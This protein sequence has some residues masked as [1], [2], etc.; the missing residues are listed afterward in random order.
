[1]CRKEVE[2]L[3]RTAVGGRSPH[4][5]ELFEVWEDNEYVCLILE[6]CAGMFTPVRVCLSMMLTAQSTRQEGR[7]L[8]ETRL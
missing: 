2:L 1:M 5:S 3:Q 8:W 7:T 4:I 6:Y